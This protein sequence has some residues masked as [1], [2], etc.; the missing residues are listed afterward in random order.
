M[1][2][3]VT[4]QVIVH[5]YHMYFSSPFL[6]CKSSFHCLFQFSAQWSYHSTVSWPGPTLSSRVQ[7]L[8]TRLVAQWLAYLWL[9]PGNKA[10]ASYPRTKA[11]GRPRPPRAWTLCFH[12]WICHKYSCM[13]TAHVRHSATHLL[14]NWTLLKPVHM[15]LILMITKKNIHVSVIEHYKNIQTAAI[16]QMD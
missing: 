13:Q 6:V 15:V 4:Y 8:G 3:H 1:Y 9:K 14:F 5:V 2:R 16:L 10:M 11:L 12:R 7:G